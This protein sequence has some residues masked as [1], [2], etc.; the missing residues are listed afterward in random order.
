[1]DVDVAMGQIPRSTER[2]SSCIYGLFQCN[3][4]WGML[5]N[6]CNATFTIVIVITDEHY[7]TALIYKRK[8]ECTLITYLIDII[9]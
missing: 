9:T 1:M 7:D 5:L 8:L 3:F 4:F 2:I 6:L